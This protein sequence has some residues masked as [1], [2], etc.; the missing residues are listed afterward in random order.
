M[1]YFVLM[2]KQL[3][4]KT[5]DHLGLVSGMIDELEIVNMIDELVPQDH[6]SRNLSIGTICKALVINGL[7][8]TQ[9]TIYMVSS[10]FEGKPAE[11]LLGEGV[12]SEHLN[13]SAIGRCLDAL[14]DYGVTDLYSQI[15]TSVCEKLKLSTSHMHMDITSFSVEGK[16]NSDSQPSEEEKTIW[17]THGYSRD[18]RPDLCQAVLNMVCENKA[19]IPLRMEALSG[20]TNDKEAFR[21][22]VDALSKEIRSGLDS[23]LMVMDSAGYTSKMIALCGDDIKWISRV[24]STIKECRSFIQTESSS[25]SPLT[26][27][28]SYFPANSNYGGTEQRWLIIFSEAAYRREAETLRKKYLKKGAE[29]SAG[30]ERLCRTPFACV[31]DAEAALAKFEKTCSFITVSHPVITENKKFS[32]PG[33]PS[34]GAKPDGAEFF[35]EGC[36]SSCIETFKSHLR[37]KGR[38]VISTNQC[39]KNTLSDRD[40]FMHYK[41]QSKIERGFR[42]IKDPQFVASSFFVKKPERLEVLIFIMTLCLTVYASLEYRLRKTIEEKEEPIPDQLGK[43][44]MKPTAR[45]VFQL[46]TDIHLLSGMDKDIILNLKDIHKK[47]LNLLGFHFQ[48]YYLLEQG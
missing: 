2:D 25:F 37:T 36:V 14:Y 47:I 39:C 46:F 18:H 7:G 34:K 23:G 26:D 10:F 5:L 27:G 44:T 48:K 19:G 9:R 30:F 22:T 38:F 4:S 33:R 42:F 43:D 29:E 20:N 8:F 13:E 3:S 21:N 41:G 31:P 1:S 32:K 6:K 45:W 16:Y 12:K 17:V 40:I 11:K 15:A 24:P 28:Y 35:I